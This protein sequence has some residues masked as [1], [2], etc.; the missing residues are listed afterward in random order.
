MAKMA[1][2]PVILLVHE[3]RAVRQALAAARTKSDG[4]SQDDRC[5]HLKDLQIQA[6]SLHNRL[7][8]TV[9]TSPIGAAELIW[10]AA[11]MLPAAYGLYAARM[12]Q[13]V[14]RLNIG[15][16]T[17]ADLQW[18]RKMA[19]A[20]ADGQCG[21]AGDAAAL[22]LL[23]LHGAA[24]PLVVYRASDVTLKMAECSA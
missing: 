2:D 3:Q 19:N 7:L 5:A 1:M 6:E 16:R 21:D 14:S 15:Q 4:R 20:V 17:L 18:L 11:D 10:L 9:P 13:I 23:A 8:Q 24:I 22:L 12:R